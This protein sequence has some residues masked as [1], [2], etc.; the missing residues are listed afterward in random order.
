[1]ADKGRKEWMERGRELGR[2]VTVG[3]RGHGR[4]LPS[5]AWW[6]RLGHH[7]PQSSTVPFRSQSASDPDHGP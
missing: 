5:S 1:M 3:H 2:G 4:P 7:A 6:Q